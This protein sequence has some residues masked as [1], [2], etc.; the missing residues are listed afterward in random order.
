MLEKFNISYL[1][2]V[3]LNISE[4]GESQHREGW[5]FIMGINEIYIYVCARDILK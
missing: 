2:I 3:Q 1:Y 4:F 5:T